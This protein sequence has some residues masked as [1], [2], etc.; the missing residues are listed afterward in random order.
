MNSVPGR[1]PCFSAITG[2]V[3]GFRVW[4]LGFGV[5]EDL[6]SSRSKNRSRNSKWSITFVSY[7]MRSSNILRGWLF[8]ILGL[9][10][11][12]HCTMKVLSSCLLA[13]LLVGMSIGFKATLH[14]KPLRVQAR[15]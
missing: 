4:G 8:G 13:R 1:V 14:P 3:E 9:K 15:S 10:R 5:W 11:S 6:N 12:L 2:A 7:C